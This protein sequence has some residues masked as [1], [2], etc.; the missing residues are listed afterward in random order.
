LNLLGAIKQLDDD[1]GRIRHTYEDVMPMDG[2]LV[3]AKRVIRGEVNSE[4]YDVIL[5]RQS[6]SCRGIA[7]GLTKN[8]A[9]GNFVV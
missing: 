8:Q 2:E 5:V 9:L 6:G 3:V 1:N 7:F 4:V